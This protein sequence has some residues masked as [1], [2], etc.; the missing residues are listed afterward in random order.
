MNIKR[1]ALKENVTRDEFR[2]EA[3]YLGW[4]L[5][6]IKDST[7]HTLYERD[8]IKHGGETSIQY[9]E[10]FFI[11]TAYISTKGEEVD[12]VAEETKSTFDCYS[13]QEILDE[14][15]TSKD[16]KRKIKLIHLAGVTAPYG[17]SD[18]EYQKF[19]DDRL[20]DRDPQIRKAVILAMAYMSWQEWKEVLNG[21]QKEDP[22]LGVRESALKMLEKIE[23]EQQEELID[24]NGDESGIEEIK[25]LESSV[26][27]VVAKNSVKDR[28]LVKC[29]IKNQVIRDIYLQVGTDVTLDQI[30]D[31][32]KYIDLFQELSQL[33]MKAKD[34]KNRNQQWIDRYEQTIGELDEN[35]EIFKNQYRL[36][37]AIN[38]IIVLYKELFTGEVL[39]E[40]INRFNGKGD[41]F[42][43]GMLDYTVKMIEDKIAEKIEK[44]MDDLLL[45][46]GLGNHLDLAAED[47]EGVMEGFFEYL[48]GAV[49]CSKKDLA[50]LEQDLISIEE[51][52]EKGYFVEN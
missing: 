48:M 22:D 50:K 3:F 10:D 20:K 16:I 29:K 44:Y 2:E 11:E 38:R 32:I 12:V 4:R 28:V 37:D 39:E 49:K 15:T 30:E 26:S 7:E 23:K 21:L 6:C 34:L 24:E 19:F 51:N 45:W 33:S 41:V 43:I 5:W 8:Y 31:H 17:E 18:P 27:I 36:M 13:W 42:E 40:N 35:S 47:P 1:I 52:P 25:K 46:D 9:T 14:Y